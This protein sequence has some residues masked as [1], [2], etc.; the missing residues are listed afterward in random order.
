MPLL[1]ARPYIPVPFS[2]WGDAPGCEVGHGKNHQCARKLVGFVQLGQIAEGKRTMTCSS[3][4]QYSHKLNV[5]SAQHMFFLPFDRVMCGSRVWMMW[6]SHWWSRAPQ[7]P[8]TFAESLRCVCVCVSVC[9]SVCVS[10][11]LCLYLPHDRYRF[12]WAS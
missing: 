9:L 5:S 8:A 12:A 7:S 10:V 2:I 11:C 1:L 4:T 3:P 6:P